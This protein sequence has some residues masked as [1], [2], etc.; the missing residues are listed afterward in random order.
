MILDGDA[1]KKLDRL[2]EKSKFMPVL[3]RAQTAQGQLNTFVVIPVDTR[4]WGVGPLAEQQLPDP[5][6]Y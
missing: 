3:K 1:D 4:S 5:A 2:L 6:W